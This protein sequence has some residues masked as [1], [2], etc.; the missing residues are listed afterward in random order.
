MTVGAALTVK[1]PVPVAVVPSPLTRVTLRVPVEA[2]PEMVML[3]VSEVELT[4]VV[5]FTVIPVPEKE[6]ARGAPVTKFVP[7]MVMFWLMAP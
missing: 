4:K 6:V 3:A 7:E 1:T 5:E 2:A